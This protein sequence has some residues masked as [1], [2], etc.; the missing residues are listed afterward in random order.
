MEAARRY[1]SDYQLWSNES[2]QLENARQERV[3]TSNEQD[4]CLGEAIRKQSSQGALEYVLQRH[5]RVWDENAGRIDSLI[6][7]EHLS[8]AGHPHTR[9]QLLR[10]FGEA[11]PTLIAELARAERIEI[12]QGLSLERLTRTAPDDERL[13]AGEWFAAQFVCAFEGY[14]EWKSSHPKIWA[15]RKGEIEVRER[16][17]AFERYLR[18]ELERAGCERVEMTKAS[19]D[20]GADLLIVHRGRRIIVQAKSFSDKVGIGAVQEVEAAR[21]FYRAQEAWV[22]IDSDF[23]PNARVLAEENGVHLI[24]GKTLDVVGPSVLGGRPLPLNELVQA[25]TLPREATTTEKTPSDAATPAEVAP[26]KCSDPPVPSVLDRFRRH[27]IH[28]VCAAVALV[29][30]SAAALWTASASSRAGERTVLLAVDQWVSTTRSLNLNGQLACYAP[31]L[32]RFYLLRDVSVDEVAKNKREAFRRFSE[33]RIYQLRNVTFEHLDNREATVV[34]DKDWDF[35]DRK[36]NRRFAGSGRQRLTFDRFGGAW[37][38][39]GEEELAVYS[40]TGS[41]T[42]K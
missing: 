40:V 18:D 29:I 37:L 19:G 11:I 14:L 33:T 28:L 7:N 1:T 26:R 2:Q 35:R 21:K 22:I 9:P 30:L 39:T 10:A 20:Y 24:D 41:A 25:N 4:A 5:R 12:R 34:F 17:V 27:S 42:G 32:K 16:G 8:L 13:F 6:R 38:I 3:H 15:E 31:K 23:T 36:S